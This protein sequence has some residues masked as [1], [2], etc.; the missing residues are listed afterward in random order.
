MSKKIVF[1]GAG[2]IGGS[3]G[4]WVAEQYENVWFLDQGEVARAIK[5]KGITTYLEHHK[6]EA[7][8]VKVKTIDSLSECAD[9]DVI[10]V[11]VKTYSL[12]KVCQIIKSEVKGNP[13]I[14]ALQNGIE[15][16]KI[17]PKYFDK[18]IYCVIEYN[19]WIDEPMVIGYQKKGAL[20]FGTNNDALTPEMNEIAGIFN[21]GVETHTT[22]RL[23]DAVHT[24]MIINL[25]NSLTTLIGL[26]FVE[27]PNRVLFKKLLTNLSYEGTKIVKA[28]GYKE[29]KVEGMPS[30][31]IMKLGCKL[32]F[33]LSK[34]IFEKNVK[35]MVISSMAQ[36]VLQRKGQAT[37]LDTLNG[38]IVALA[39]KFNVKAPYNKA[40][41]EMCRREFAKP[42]FKPVSVEAVYAEVIKLTGGK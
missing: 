39:D 20:I 25:T 6:D 34:G 7:V 18:V 10:V 13:T 32:P 3:V 9:A 36:D 28:A 21:L 27:I 17:I 2:A 1:F 8:N 38:Y 5:E 37:E 19:A 33:F 24:K 41:Y 15:N 42:D 29:F 22:D 11:C 31:T 14:V 30:W 16:Q 26:N 40:V 4:A 35:K 23:L 12:D